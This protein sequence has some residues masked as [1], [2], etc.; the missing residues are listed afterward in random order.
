MYSLG[1]AAFPHG[2]VK[3]FP[4][5]TLVIINSFLSVLFSGSLKI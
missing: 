1:K 3:Y 2:L 4:I 5:V